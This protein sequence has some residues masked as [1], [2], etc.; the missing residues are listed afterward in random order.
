MKNILSS[1]LY[2]F[3]RYFSSTS[4]GRQSQRPLTAAPKSTIINATSKHKTIS[5]TKTASEES[6]MPAPVHSKPSDN[7]MVSEADRRPLMESPD[8]ACQ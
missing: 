6:S 1:V 7:F 5:R 8:H 4:T 3:Y 2:N